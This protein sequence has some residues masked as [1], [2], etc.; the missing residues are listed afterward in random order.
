MF[1]LIARDRA[2]GFFLSGVVGLVGEHARFGAAAATAFL[3]DF[4]RLLG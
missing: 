2:A 1:G 4:L 3:A